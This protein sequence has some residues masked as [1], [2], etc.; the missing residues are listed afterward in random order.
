MLAFCLG[1]QVIA[2]ALGGLVRQRTGPRKHYALQESELLLRAPPHEQNGRRNGV[3]VNSSSEAAGSVVL[4]AVASVRRQNKQ[5]GGAVVVQQGDNDALTKSPVTM[6]LL[7]HHNDEVGW[8]CSRFAGYFSGSF[9]CRLGG[10][11]ARN[12]VGQ[13]VHGVGAGSSLR[14]MLQFCRLMLA[15][16]RWH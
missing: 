14:K 9:C 2:Q 8:R 16:S 15:P 7:Y 13:R 4:E 11:A 12:I 5:R 1:H 6:R 10:F 3:V